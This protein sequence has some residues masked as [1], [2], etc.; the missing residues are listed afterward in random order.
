MKIT[1]YTTSNFFGSIQKHEG[2]LIETGRRKYAQYDNAPF[3]DFIPKGKRKAVRILKSYKPYLLICAGWNCPNT[4]GMFGAE[5]TKEYP[6]GH[7]KIR[8]SRYSSFDDGYKKD[9]DVI[10]DNMI[11]RGDIVV[12]ADYRDKTYCEV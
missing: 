8:Q 11:T 12:V 10:I 4:Q 9:F 2:T 3:V 7:V 6:E 1:I 5:E